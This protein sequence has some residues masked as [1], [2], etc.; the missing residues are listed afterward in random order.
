MAYDFTRIAVEIEGGVA[1]ATISDPPMNVMTVELFG[2][3]DRLSQEI[4]ADDAVRVLVLKAPIRFLHRAFRRG[5]HPGP[6]DRPAGGAVAQAQA[7]PRHVRTLP[8]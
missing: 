7:L 2:E 3:L 8:G 6:A 4:E 1:R 5:E